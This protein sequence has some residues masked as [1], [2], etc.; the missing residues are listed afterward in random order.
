MNAFSIEKLRFEVNPDDFTI[1][2]TV[3]GT[4][5]KGNKKI[6][7]EKVH[8]VVWYEV[9]ELTAILADALQVCQRASKVL[10]K[11]ARQDA[12]HAEIAGLHRDILEGR[13]REKPKEDGA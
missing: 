4:G 8:G 13:E 11:Q 10:E 6:S 9:S 7:G 12:K 3:D 1:M 5:C 2:M